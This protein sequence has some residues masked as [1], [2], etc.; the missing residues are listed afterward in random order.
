MVMLDIHYIRNQ[1]YNINPGRLPRFDAVYIKGKRE[2]YWSKF[3]ISLDDLVGT[4]R[5][6]FPNVKDFVN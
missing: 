5:Y 1:V 6:K 2:C 3:E 4:L